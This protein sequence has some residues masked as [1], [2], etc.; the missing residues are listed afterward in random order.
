MT[1]I[2][3]V[4]FAALA[5]RVKNILIKPADEWDKISAEK[6]LL[7]DLFLRYLAI[8][9]AIPAVCGFVGALAFGYGYGASPTMGYALKTLVM[10]YIMSFVTAGAGGLIVEYL[11]PQFGGKA[12]RMGAFKLV[13]Y[14]ATA[15]WMAGIFSLMPSF[16]KILGLL[17]LYSI[18]LFYLGAPKMV[19][20]PADKAG[21]FTAVVVVATFIVGLVLTTVMFF[22]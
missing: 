11:A 10:S 21:T 16:L 22:T 6:I 1:A 5:E 18:Y 3:G 4:D 7:P 13:I 14:S 8:L 2:A 15:S 12:D 19:G 9:A 20:V 17:G